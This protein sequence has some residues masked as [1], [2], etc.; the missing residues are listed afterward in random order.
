M[1]SS[2]R[3]QCNRLFHFYQSI[4]PYSTSAFRRHVYRGQLN[5]AKAA[6]ESLPPSPI[7][8]NLLKR[9]VLLVRNGGTKSDLGFLQQLLHDLPNRFQQPLTHFEYNALIY[10]YGVHQLPKKAQALFEEMKQSGIQPNIYTYNTLL[11]VYKERGE[12]EQA[13]A[14]FD[15][16]KEPDT[17]TYNTMLQLWLQTGHKDRVFRLYDT[18]KDTGD[19]YTYSI[20]L[21]AAIPENPEVAQSVFDKL[22]IRQDLDTTAMNTMLRYRADELEEKLALF[23]RLKQKCKPDRTTFNILLDMCLKN[24]NPARAFMIYREMKHERIR[25]DLITYGTLIHAEAR[26][27][28]LKGALDLFEELKKRMKPNR[29]IVNSLVNMATL[30]TSP[31]QLDRLL[32]VIKPYEGQLDTMAYNMLIGGLA[33]FGRSEQVQEIY[34]RVFRHEKPDIATFTHLILAYANDNCVDDA[35]EIYQVLREHHHQEKAK[36]RLDATFYSTLIASLSTVKED[37]N[38]RLLAALVLFNDMR[39]L[40][41]QPSAHTYTAMLH[42]CGQY[43]DGYVLEHVYGLIKVDLYLDPDIGIYN[44]LMDAYNR[45]GDGETVLEIW[46]QLTTSSEVVIDPTTVSIVFDSCGHNGHFDRAISIWRWLQ[47]AGFKLNT[48]NYTSYI[49][50]LCRIPGRAGFDQALEV[51]RSMS[52]PKHVRPGQPMIDQKTI[53]TLHSF[54]RKKGISDYFIL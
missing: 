7:D 3:V 35:L 1:F 24:G 43:R 46:Q 53:N 9:L 45:T 20:I 47:L 31:S 29:R 21:D 42:A 36:V 54:A 50:C 17:V 32:S 26:G 6:Y 13:Q 15:E 28:T 16:I 27:G 23:N 4:Q 8:R 33:Q 38:E 34:D 44:A 48:N 5:Q 30:A 52:R 22:M 10:A 39:S 18:L 25:P 2:G 40:G 19:V 51:A 49:E 37:N 41:I 14:L 11:Q 12:L